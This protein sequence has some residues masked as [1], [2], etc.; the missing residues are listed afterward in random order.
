MRRFYISPENITKEMPI[1]TGS[2]AVHIA[3][4]LR[5]KTGDI[6]TL[7]DGSGTEY[8]AKILQ[9][10]PNRVQ[11]SILH[12]RIAD[13]ELP[14]YITIAQGFLKEKKM[15]R[16]VR[17]L[18]E[19]GVSQWIP[20]QAIRSVVRLNAKRLDLRKERWEKI[21]VEAAKQC[22]RNRL[23]SIEPVASFSQVLDRYTEFHQGLIFWE[24]ETN[25][26]KKVPPKANIQPGSRII[27]LL[28]PEGGFDPTEIQAAKE[29]G[30]VTAGLGPRILRAETAAVAA[31]A[32]IQFIFGD[33]G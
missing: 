26:L 23:M 24:K 10:S 20:F 29:K 8:K 12:H 22:G 19:I 4:V 15:D 6:I 13:K 14:I 27:I 28:G 3:Q 25:G 5:Y 30:F 2:D 16:V 18:S 1:L 33:M 9:L 32:L 31:G 11:V 21:A 17:Q 7:F